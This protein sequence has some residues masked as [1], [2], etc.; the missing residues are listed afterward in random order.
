MEFDILKNRTYGTVRVSIEYGYE[1]LAAWFNDELPDSSGLVESLT[2]VVESPPK[3]FIQ[4]QGRAFSLFL[5]LDEVVVVHHQL[6]SSTDLSELLG[7]SARSVID[8]DE[9]IFLPDDSLNVDEE[10][11]QASCGFDDFLTLFK[12]WLEEI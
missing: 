7:E 12:C 3:Q 9:E 2:K 10:S 1:A 11:L 8:W 5:N 4:L 6:I